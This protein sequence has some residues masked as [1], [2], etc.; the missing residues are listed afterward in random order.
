[1]SN[2]P[3]E[4]EV[5]NS[6]ENGPP[7]FVNIEGEIYEWDDATITAEEIIN[8]GGWDLDLGV[9][10]IDLRTNETRTLEPDEVIEI[11]PG[12]GFSKKIKWKRGL[13]EER[14][15]EELEILKSVF[16][17]VE[18]SPDGHWFLIPEYPFMPKDPVW[19][20][21]PMPIAFY[22]RDGYPGQKPYGIY[23]PSDVTVEGEKPN[24]FKES[25]NVE[26]PF[27]GEW[28][29]LSWQPEQWNPGSN[30]REGA[31]LNALALTLKERFREGK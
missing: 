15:K 27:E 1:M 2:M 17:D 29:Q 26:P 30:A 13:L 11:H 9:Q 31:N 18:Y 23:V 8:L 16:P 5:E 22:P 24:N 25:P 21:D 20:P 7:Y 3:D 6:G 14:I 12:R 10:E 28:G 4:S 19:S